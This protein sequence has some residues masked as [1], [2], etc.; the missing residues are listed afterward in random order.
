MAS[1]LLQDLEKLRHM[2]GVDAHRPRRQWAYRNYFNAA[3]SDV[4]SME[5]LVALGF[6][7]QYRPDYWRATEA[8]CKAVGL[9]EKETRKALKGD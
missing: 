4:A 5:R 7:Q 8:G 3:G 1:E 9:T 2:L 6:A